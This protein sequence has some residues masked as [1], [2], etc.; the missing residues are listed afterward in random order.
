MALFGTPS[1]PGAQ[2]G[3]SPFGAGA[4]A[5]GLFSTPAPTGSVFGGGGGLFGSTPAFGQSSGG[6]LFGSTTPSTPA[7]GASGQQQGTSLFGQTPSPFGQTQQTPSP[8]GQ[9]QQT[10]AFG[11]TQPSF[12]QMPQT[13]AF[14]QA[15]QSPLF[16]G[17]QQQQQQQTSPFNQAPGGMFGGQQQASPFNQ[18]P[19]GMFGQQQSNMFSGSL[20]TQM[21]PVAPVVVPLPDREIQAIVDAY[22]DDVGNPQDGFKYLLLSVTDPAA[23]FKPVGVSDILWAEA[24]NKLE[25]LDSMDRERLW[26]EMVHG[27]KDLSRRMKL[28]DE[29]ISADLQR[30]QATESNVKLLRRHFE[31]DT[32]PCIQRL[33]QKEQELQRR[34]LKIMRMVEALEGKGLHMGLTRGEA[35]LGDHL[36]G[37][38]RQ[39]QGASAELPRRVETLLSVSRMQVGCGGGS[40]SMLLGPGKID[41]QSLVDM[42]KVL[43]QQTEAISR[44]DTV[45]KKDMRDIDI[46]LT[47]DTEMMDGHVDTDNG[48]YHGSQALVGFTRKFY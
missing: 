4:G 24:M 3:S 43:Q 5:G 32:L 46:I 11:Q 16:G 37:L 19:G 30:L 38:T 15:G 6:G 7:F 20:Q 41:N 25:G 47:E 48:R 34:L 8:F 26:P 45:L 28:Q 21:A 22:R 39:L 36:R 2:P 17:Q 14:G 31:T 44:L 33:R 1:T 9:T 40:Q 29:A 12:G 10:P 18:T 23:R 13:S 35:R 42:H 27:F